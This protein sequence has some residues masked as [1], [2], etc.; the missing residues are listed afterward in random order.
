[1]P[2][3]A[4][5]KPAAG[6]SSR[7][8]WDESP[9]AHE[10]FT[11]HN[12]MM[13]VGDK[14]IAPLGLTSS[15]WLLLGALSQYDEPPSLSQLSSNTLLTVQNVSRMVGVLE[16]DGLLERFTRSGAGRTT[17]IRLT[18]QGED[19]LA[20]ARAACPL[21]SRWFLEGLSTERIRELEADLHRIIRNLE[22]LEQ[23][24]ESGEVSLDEPD[25]RKEDAA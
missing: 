9:L 8:K 7:A 13:R 4:T 2:Q 18:E 21:F 15:R 5:D 10:F 3:R 20:R 17:F 14:F 24:I 12:L 6:D 19:T 25:D 16:A 23:H 22:R 1:M 11:I